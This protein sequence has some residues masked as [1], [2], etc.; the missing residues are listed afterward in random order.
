MSTVAEIEAAIE[1]LSLEEQRQLW[2]WFRERALPEDNDDVLVPPAYRQK[3]LD[4]ID[5]P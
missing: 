3:I 4:A 5:Q 2:Q 1:Q